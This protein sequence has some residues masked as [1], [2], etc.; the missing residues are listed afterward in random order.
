MATFIKTHAAQTYLEELFNA[1]SHGLGALLG[2][3]ALVVLVATSSATEHTMKI[4]SSVVYGSSLI[5]MYSASTFYHLT[6][7]PHIK[8][9]LKIL[10]HSCI[11]ILIAGSYTPYTLVVLNGGWGWSLFGVTWGLA[12]SGVIFKLFFTGRFEWL[13]LT[14]YL[15]MGWMAVF[16]LKPL[17]ENLPL[18]GILWLV[19][20]GL[21]YT[22]GV[23][24]Y[25]ID[26]KYHLSHFIWHLFV[27][28]GSICQFFAVLLYVIG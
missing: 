21:F 27:L 5:L 9:I 20:G 22:L 11:Y 18:G 10:D 2:V 17:I 13:S 25:A 24:F 26:G 23:I 14:I 15:L 3:V 12:L 16:A 4:V 28:A 1:I 7:R 8:K 6:Q 19:A